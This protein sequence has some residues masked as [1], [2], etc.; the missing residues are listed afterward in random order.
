MQPARTIIE[1]LLTIGEPH[2]PLCSFREPGNIR[3]VLCEHA[4]REVKVPGMREADGIREES[5]QIPHARTP[6]GLPWDSKVNDSQV[7]FWREESTA[8]SSAVDAR[9]SERGAADVCCISC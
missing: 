9:E 5:S 1:S 6:V 2:C 3:H 4:E 8:L 7:G